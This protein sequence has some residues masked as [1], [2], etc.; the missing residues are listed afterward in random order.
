MKYRTRKKIMILLFAYFICWNMSLGFANQQQTVYVLVDVSGSVPYL[1]NPSFARKIGGAVANRILSLS[2]G[3]DVHIV[4]FGEF[5]LHNSYS[6]R[7]KLRPANETPS[8]V[9][10]EIEWY[11]SGLPTL[12]AQ[13]KIRV[14]NETN[15]V[16]ALIK[17]KPARG[18]TVIVVSDFDENVS[19]PARKIVNTTGAFFPSNQALL[20]GISVVGYG[21]GLTM[22]SPREYERLRELWLIWFKTA[23]VN[24]V[25]LH[26]D[27]F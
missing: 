1:Q 8:G 26:S 12:V 21:F 3:S 7:L 22:S 27:D 25:Q 18:S 13:H 17:L 19:F 14:E 16:G 4:P 5:T 2:V 15:L 10:K 23:G 24:D 9:A 6:Y 11:I 20:Q